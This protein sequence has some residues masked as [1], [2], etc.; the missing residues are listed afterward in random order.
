[1][2]TAL[3]TALIGVG[4]L[5][6]CR[7]CDRD[8]SLTACDT[9]KRKRIRRARHPVLR[10]A[11][12]VIALYAGGDAVSVSCIKCKP[13]QYC[14][15]QMTPVDA[16]YA[17]SLSDGNV[18]ATFIDGRQD[19]VLDIMCDILLQDGTTVKAHR[20]AFIYTRPVITDCLERLRTPRTT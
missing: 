1:M 16:K 19:Q 17:L 5:P 13:T 7:V 20:V 11:G 9:E 3:N 15:G 10:T 2:I 4:R 6:T 14:G 18:Y 8:V 12:D